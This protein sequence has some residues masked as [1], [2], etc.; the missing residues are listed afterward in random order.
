MVRKIT[1]TPNAR[2]SRLEIFSYWDNRNK[3]KSYSQKLNLEY[4]KAL[5]QVAKIPQIGIETNNKNVRLTLVSHFEIIY[6]IS[7]TE[8]KVL[9]IW[10]TRQNP[11]HHHI[12]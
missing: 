8:I 4:K 7:D 5:K 11:V 1:W 3:S 10:D 2:K 9:D 6:F 12:K